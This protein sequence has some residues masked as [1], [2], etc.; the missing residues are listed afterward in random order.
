MSRY[1]CHDKLPF[2]ELRLWQPDYREFCCS[3]ETAE[4]L[5]AGG[6]TSINDVPVRLQIM[7]TLVGGQNV[8]VKAWVDQTGLVETETAAVS[9]E[10]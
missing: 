3:V 7:D 5:M 1:W 8:M 6:M 4:W 9:V 10:A 2:G